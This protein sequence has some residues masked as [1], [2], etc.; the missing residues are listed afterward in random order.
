MFRRVLKVAWERMPRIALGFI[1]PELA[2]MRVYTI[3]TKTLSPKR[4]YTWILVSM[5]DADVGEAVE[6]LD[7]LY[8]DGRDNWVPPRFRRE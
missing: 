5:G 6:R 4:M 2:P 3:K 7:G 1:D 8:V